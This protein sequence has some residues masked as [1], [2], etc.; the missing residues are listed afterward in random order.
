MLEF[1]DLED[2]D[3]VA[4]GDVFEWVGQHRQSPWHTFGVV[5]T[6]D[7]DLAR[8]KHNG[9]ISYIPAWVALDFLWHEWRPNIFSPMREK[10][11]ETVAFRI[12]KW[13]VKNGH[14]NSSL[15]AGAINDWIKR[16]GAEG[17]LDELKV[18]DAGQRNTLLNVIRPALAYDALLGGLDP[19]RNLLLDA[20]AYLRPAAANDPSVLFR[21]IEKSWS[22]LPEDVF[23]L[24]ST[25]FAE[26]DDLFLRLR[27][28]RQIRAEEVTARPD[29]IRSGRAKVKRIA[30]VMAPYRYAITQSLAKVF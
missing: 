4:Q 30:R 17:M 23:H 10:A 28:I 21:E 12:T 29:D 14:P 3:T 25:P 8:G 22:S 24:P 16:S 26:D 15:S 18:V 13:L 5:V 7:C 1:E 9:W 19:N 11:F 20:Y 2:L 6:A 27:H